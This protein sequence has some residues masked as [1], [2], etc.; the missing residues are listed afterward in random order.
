MSKSALSTPKRRYI[1]SLYSLYMDIHKTLTV[2]GTF[3]NVATLLDTVPTVFVICHLEEYP[4]FEN[5]YS[6]QI[7]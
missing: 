1:S 7:T 5:K 4:V 2:G 3:R 6:I